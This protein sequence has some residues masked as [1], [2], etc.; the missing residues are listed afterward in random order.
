MLLFGISVTSIQGVFGCS[1]DAQCRAGLICDGMVMHGTHDGFCS[2]LLTH[3][4][5]DSRP[6]TAARENHYLVLVDVFQILKYF[7]DWGSVSVK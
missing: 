2:M 4:A 3:C 6:G 5:S 1:Q 7:E